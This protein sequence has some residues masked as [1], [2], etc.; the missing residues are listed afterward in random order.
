MPSDIAESNYGS[1][2]AGLVWGYVF[3]REQAGATI[4]SE[5]AAALLAAGPANDDSF[6]WL[7]FTLANAASE[8][9]LREHVALP[10]A[11][12]ESLHGSTSTRVEHADDALVAVLNDVM[13]FD[14]STVSCVSLCVQRQV[15]VSARRTALRSIDRLR[16]SVRAGETFRS[17]SELLAHL[18]RDQADVLVQIVRDATKE[19]DAIEDKL[20]ASVAGMN[21]AKLGALRRVLV[22]LRRL[23]A[24]EPAALFR[25][26]NRPPSWLGTR[27][28]EDFRQS[29]EELT[30]AVSEAAAL[31][32]RIR[33]IQEEML[34]LVDERTNHTLFVLTVVTVLSLPLT[35]VP[36]LFGMNVGG[37]PFA[38]HGVGFWMVVALLT[39][40][41]GVGGFL[42]YRTYGTSVGA[43]D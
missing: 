20:M 41:V 15:L 26:L 37:I 40:W 21:R 28:L 27:D 8:R 14:M 9:W 30:L 11:F 18:L 13:Y 7:H 31:V 17:P 12:H 6:L 35:I 23:L 32:E 19:V 39:G 38:Q 2:K 3:P 29:A 34:A 25:L 43:K 33:L 24:P 4:D 22:R 16:N 36:G 1:D 5:R 42:V 10:E